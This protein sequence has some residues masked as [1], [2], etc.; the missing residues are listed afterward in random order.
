M[1]RTT[2]P[3]IEYLVIE[4]RRVDE[5]D[6]DLAVAGVAA[7]GG[8]P[9]RPAHLR[10]AAGLVDDEA[11][12]AR[13]L[14]G[15]RA[16]ALDQEVRQDAVERQARVVV[17]SRA[18]DERRP[19]HGCQVGQRLHVE[20]SAARHG[21]ADGRLGQPLQVVLGQQRRR[22]GRTGAGRRRDGGA[23][24][25]RQRARRAFGHARVD[26]GQIR[27]EGVGVRGGTQ[28]LEPLE[29]RHARVA[30][31]V[32]V[33]R[34]QA[35]ER[36]E[37]R[38]NGGCAV[39][40]AR[41][42]GCRR[43]HH[44]E[45]VR[46]QRAHVDRIRIVPDGPGQAGDRRVAH[47]V[48]RVSRQAAQRL[49]VANLRGRPCRV[50]SALPRPA[51]DKALDVGP[52]PHRGRRCQRHQGVRRAMP[53]R[54]GPRQGQVQ[55][56]LDRLVLGMAR[57][58]EQ[59]DGEQRHVIG[60]V[61]DG[62]KDR[63]ASLGL[64][65]AA[66]VD[67]QRLVADEPGRVG[68]GPFDGLAVR[69]GRR[70]R[71]PPHLEVGVARGAQRE[72]RVHRVDRQKAQQRQAPGAG[73]VLLAALALRGGAGRGGID[74]HHLAQ[75]GDCSSRERLLRAGLRPRE[76]FQPP[77]RAEQRRHGDERLAGRCQGQP[78]DPPAGRLLFEAAGDLP[79]R[80]DVHERSLDL[81]RRRRGVE[82]HPAQRFA[83]RAADVRIALSDQP[84]Q[85]RL[86]HAAGGSRIVADGHGEGVGGLRAGARLLGLEDGEQRVDEAQAFEA[87][88]RPHGDRLQ[89][90]GGRG[91][92]D[93]QLQLLRRRRA[94]GL[95]LDQGGARQHE[96]VAVTLRVGMC[97]EQGQHE[98]RQEERPRSHTPKSW[99]VARGLSMAPPRVRWVRRDAFPSTRAS[100]PRSRAG[101]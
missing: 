53:L 78:H 5:V 66:S 14:V 39:G 61:A 68:Q 10:V 79:E 24:P 95:G 82:R 16:S 38:G 87:T 25:L 33:E 29:D 81:L 58:G 45:V 77:E 70:D 93:Q 71:E 40:R 100:A 2:R 64:L 86:A 99:A 47:V 96:T 62:G 12:A 7:A 13:E 11:A 69:R 89:P 90:R 49:G 60:L 76:R 20:F 28:L 9:D 32:A 21:D 26:V 74:G 85:H 22:R 97:A 6:V 55:Q 72:R 15:A 84:R 27:L 91:S 98:D 37:Q 3:K 42:R 17:S 8:H 43:H 83:D 51:V 19:R 63:R 4:A 80:R 36:R 57:I 34:R 65:K 41:E 92:A 67:A 35:R 23:G 56:G 18:V 88:E 50:H 94:G 52:R 73:G 1:P 31:G 46:R 30:R 44:L 59:V 54:F 75:A 101:R 48:V